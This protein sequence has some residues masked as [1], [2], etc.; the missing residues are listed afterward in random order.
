[1]LFRSNVGIGTD[2]PDT[3]GSFWKK[4]VDIVGS[5]NAIL[6]LKANSSIEGRFYV[7]NS[8]MF[9]G[10]ESDHTLTL[11]TKGVSHMTI[12]SGGKVGIG[13]NNPTAQLDVNGDL[14]V[15]SGS[16]SFGNRNGQLINLH[17]T[18]HG[19]GVQKDS[20]QKIGRAHV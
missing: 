19:I 11:G 15:S 1:M 12:L 14:S 9:L 5:T 13:T 6:S 7:A 18:S 8:V 4:V 16:L 10:T 17:G 20:Q 2:T 3:R